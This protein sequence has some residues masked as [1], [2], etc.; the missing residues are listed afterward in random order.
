MKRPS[1]TI[2]AVI[3]LFA[4][5][6]VAVAV[7]SRIFNYVD[8]VPL[9]VL[10]LSMIL[11]ISVRRGLRVELVATLALICIFVA[12]LFGI[13]GARFFEQLL[14][15]GIAAPAITTAIVTELIGWLTYAFARS[16]NPQTSRRMQWSPSTRQIV[17][18]VAAILLF[19]IFYTSL[20]SS[21]Y[22]EQQGIYP[23]FY[24]LLGNTLALM[25]M[26]CGN[27]IF[28]N[29]R[30]RLFR[31]RG[32]RLAASAL[33]TLGFVLLLTAAV[34]FG[35]PQGNGAALSARH[36]FRLYTVVLLVDIV[37][38]AM[39]QLAVYVIESHRE[40]RSE[41]GKKHRA[42]FHYD[43]LKQQINPHFLFNSLN[44][45][46]YLV[47]EHETE[48]ASA[49]IRKL[50]ATYRY[51]LKK[52]DEQLVPLE[53]EL[54]FARQYIDL[55]QERFTK[56]F[57]VEVDIPRPLLRRY[58]VPCCLQLL[59][60]NAIKHNVV[61]PEQPLHVRIAA[62]GD[63]LTVSNNLQLRMNAPASTGVGLRNIRQQYLD[64]A[65]AP[66]LVERTDTEFRVQLPLL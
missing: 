33:F 50:A 56:G 3:H 47:Q 37:V 51:M 7:L 42:L 8:D 9:T 20:F 58:V 6:H 21:P 4:A 5:A 53:E 59:I 27:I 32:L 36:F 66:I 52:A 64:T 19:R 1:I 44:I 10:T 41:R 60:E 43:R 57:E 12:Y 23:E 26:F 38:Y 45:L 34:Y 29:Q 62:A 2:P 48:R 63:R 46:D 28:V 39:L 18:S 54:E 13:Y 15:C 61:S 22:F 17:V 30:A 35:L 55:L 24:R 11:I 25:T 14:G 31:R 49:F 65:G 16:R 40:L